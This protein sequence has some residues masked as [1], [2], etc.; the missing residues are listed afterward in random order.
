MRN[1]K[2]MSVSQSQKIISSGNDQVQQESTPQ[3]N[4]APGIVRKP[5]GKK[6]TPKV[7]PTI[8]GARKV[9]PIALDNSPIQQNL[10]EEDTTKQQSPDEQEKTEVHEFGESLRQEQA[11][12]E[13][14]QGENDL[15]FSQDQPGFDQPQEEMADP[16]LPLKRPFITRPTP[17]A[18][19]GAG[20]RGGIVRGGVRGGGPAPARKPMPKPG[21]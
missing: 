12:D 1:E 3:T 5:F 10:T 4:A 18:R 2:V 7:V 20:A 11:N 9:P 21:V 6:L 17:I 19:G 15:G 8:S 14:V 16:G 13:V